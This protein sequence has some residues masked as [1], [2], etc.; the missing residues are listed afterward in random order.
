MKKSVMLLGFLV[1]T[2]GCAT[3]P[4]IPIVNLYPGADRIRIGRSDAPSNYEEVKPITVH[5]GYGCGTW[6]GYQGTY[7]RAETM[8]RDEAVQVGGD[9]VQ[10]LT[11]A[12]PYSD[13]DCFHNQ[14]VITGIIY[15]SQK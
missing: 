15:K 13:G 6:N 5:D 14:Y 9:Y 7:E 12:P 1:G 2:M 8:L 3:P 11:I 4:H 10:I